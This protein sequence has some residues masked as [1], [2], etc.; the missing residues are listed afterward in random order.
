MYDSGENK[1]AFIAPTEASIDEKFDRLLKQTDLEDEHMKISH[2][3][4]SISA[5]I[6]GLLDQGAIDTEI[7]EKLM[8]RLKAR[9]QQEWPDFDID[10][11]NVVG[12]DSGIP[13]KIKELIRKNRGE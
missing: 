6:S 7:A 13:E 8:T 3:Y 2:I 4:N 9:T 10:T 11:I 1:S 5:P 12:R